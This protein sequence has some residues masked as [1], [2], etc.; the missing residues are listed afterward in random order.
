MKLAIRVVVF[1]LV[2]AWGASDA[3]AVG[4]PGGPPAPPERPAQGIAAAVNVQ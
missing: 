3:L 2:L 1:A 4:G